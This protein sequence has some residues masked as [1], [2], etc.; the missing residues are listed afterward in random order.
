VLEEG[1]HVI[2]YLVLKADEEAAKGTDSTDI[3]WDAML[4]QEPWWAMRGGW[5][6]SSHL[7][8]LI[9]SALLP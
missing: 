6:Y 9:K 1:K 7:H 4:W 2:W 5:S 8:C 3:V